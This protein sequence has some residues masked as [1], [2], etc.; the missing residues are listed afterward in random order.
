MRAET[1]DAPIWGTLQTM[2]HS[3]GHLRVDTGALRRASDILASVSGNFVSTG[4][5]N[6]GS[7]GVGDV[8]HPGLSFAISDFCEQA[9][10][11]AV[12][13]ETAV[14][15]LG[16]STSGAGTAY[17]TTEHGIASAMEGRGG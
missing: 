15:G 8:G 17:E 13:L 9:R 10:R 6:I 1:S 3:G 11:V 7:V 5:G 12:D 14:S 16:T 2:G 4:G